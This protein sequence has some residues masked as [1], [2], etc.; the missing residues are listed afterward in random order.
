MIDMRDR[1]LTV[2]RQMNYRVEWLWINNK[3]KYKKDII[4]EIHRLLSKFST[5]QKIVEICGGTGYKNYYEEIITRDKY[6]Y[7]I[8]LY[9]VEDEYNYYI[10]VFS[11]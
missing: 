11:K 3:L 10:H 9:P 8:R 2:R 6:I 1:V 4:L 5:F 7:V